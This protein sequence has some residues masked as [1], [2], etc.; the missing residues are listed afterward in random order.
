MWLLQRLIA[1]DYKRLAVAGAVATALY[2]LEMYLDMA[3]TGNGADDV[4]LI[5]GIVR[6]ER[7]RWPLVGWIGQLCNGFGLAGVYAAI[8]T[9]LLPGPGWLRGLLF[10]EGFVLVVWPL[11]PLLDRYHP[12]IRRGEMPRYARLVPFIQNIVRHGVFGLVLGAIY[13]D[14]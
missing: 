6:K 13:R 14:Q 5:E 12:L 11:T 1:L 2:T 8:F 3:L 7:R 10:G 4:Q 9:R